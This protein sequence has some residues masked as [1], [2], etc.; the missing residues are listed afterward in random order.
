M[1]LVNLEPKELQRA[2]LGVHQ[3]DPLAEKIF[4]NVK[5]QNETGTGDF[6]DARLVLQGHHGFDL[7][8]EI[9]KHALESCMQR[10]DGSEAW[11]LAQEKLASRDPG[12]RR[13]PVRDVCTGWTHGTSA[14]L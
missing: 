8:R 5:I 1:H 13:N 2:R 11:H 9:A 14:V 12:R 3:Y 4:E 7:D 6:K 10:I